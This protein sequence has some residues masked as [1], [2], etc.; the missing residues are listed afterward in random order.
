MH[1]L[2][3]G[4]PF[5]KLSFRS[6]ILLLGTLVAVL[7][8][9]VLF[10]IVATLRYTKSAVLRH[11]KDRLV[12][13]ARTLA[14]EYE[15]RA[16]LN[17]RKNLSS[18]LS[19]PDVPASQDVLALLSRVVLQDA[20]GAGGGFYSSSANALLGSYTLDG[21]RVSDSL[22]SD[23]NS[24]IHSNIL[25][26]AR[27]AALTSA[28]AENVIF[29]APG[30]LI[31][32]AVPL[33]DGYSVVGS[34]WSVRRLPDLPGANRFRAY[35]V[36]AGLGFTALACVLLTMLVSNSL[37]GGVRKIETS[38]KMLE[39][40]LTTQ[41]ETAG[42][43]KEIQSIVEAINRLGC[44]LR[45]KIE[46]E[47]QFA[48]QLRHSERLASLGRLVAGVA[49]EVRNPLATIRLRVQMCSRESNNPRVR[50]SCSIA[51]LEIERLNGMV[52]RLLNFARPVQLHLQAVDLRVLLEERIDSCREL[53]ARYRVIISTDFSGC[54][55]PLLLDH[56][57]MGQVFDNLIQNAVEAMADQ[58]GTLSVL[59]NHKDAQN[60]G[61]VEMCVEFRDTGKGMSAAT[62]GHAFD[63][64]FTT[65]ASGT[66]L[67]LSICHELVSAHG[68][69]IRAQSELDRG[70]TVRITLP[71]RS[72]S[73]IP[74]KLQADCI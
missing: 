24:V 29:N 65:K 26:V 20:E 22:T 33:R 68:G 70:T 6:Q 38:L 50:E 8:I 5:A 37:Q 23:R 67:G 14:Q 18:P 54:S 63:P 45:E 43:P 7:S 36:S 12:Q 17:R 41:I 64:F 69:E 10:A 39:S 28:P 57:R 66:G 72:S 74:Q 32:E 2:R 30:I 59:V 15:D 60:N 55:S 42:E 9:A 34:A 19:A 46:R 13:T 35:L 21:E 31:I 62:L 27:S 53:A 40:N 11:E 61:Q 16:D 73:D 48:N 47:K 56:D 44:A 1:L 25:S 4:H 51:L 52:N 3:S 71:F 58:G 49:H